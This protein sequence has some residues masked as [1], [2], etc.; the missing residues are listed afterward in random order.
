[1]DTIAVLQVGAIAGAFVLLAFIIESLVEHLVATPLKEV[2][3]ENT[4]W[5]R[6]VALA[7]GVGLCFGLKADLLS[8]LLKA[9]ETAIEVPPAIGY[10]VTGFL[11]SRGSNFVS[12]LVQAFRP[13]RKIEP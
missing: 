6:Y 9:F 10:G 3:I 11:I 4:W 5:L 1:M 7:A 2:G 8:A 12:D 13:E